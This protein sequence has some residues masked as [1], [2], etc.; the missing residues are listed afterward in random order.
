VQAPGAASPPGVSPPV[1]TWRHPIAATEFPRARSARTS[2]AQG[3]GARASSPQEEAAHRRSRPEA[4]TSTWAYPRV[5]LKIAIASGQRSTDSTI[6]GRWEPPAGLQCQRRPPERG[7]TPARL[8]EDPRGTSRADQCCAPWASNR[9]CD[10]GRPSP[11]GRQRQTTP[12]RASL[13]F[14]AGSRAD[15]RIAAAV[16]QQRIR[17]SA[18]E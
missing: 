5:R 14:C 9:T 16:R 7:A 6:A 13:C 10:P 4:D 15:G 12:A 11:P 2:A 8:R 18:S 1:L 17:P 3:H